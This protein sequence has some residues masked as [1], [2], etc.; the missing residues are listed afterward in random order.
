MTRYSR[1]AAMALALACALPLPAR[2]AEIFASNV[3]NMFRGEAPGSIPGQWYG[4]ALSGSFP[5]ALADFEVPGMVLG[6]RDDAFVSLPGVGLQPPGS[7]FR[8]AYIEVDFGADFDANHT[9]TIYEALRSGEDA[10]VW[11]W[12]ADGGFLQLATDPGVP[13]DA[14]TF[15]LRPYAALLASHGGRFTRVGIGGLD[16]G[17][18]SQGFDLDAVSITAT[19]VPEPETY[20][21]LVAGLGML[22]WR[23]H[24]PGG[25]GKG[26]RQP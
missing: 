26:R 19:A 17:G 7:A 11:V 18:T 23:A 25:R 8:G 3:T 21:L 14:Y 13:G 2:A 24:R 1:L 22:W 9:L 10:L 15:D 12:F 4:G 16:L 5:V 20:A 6:A